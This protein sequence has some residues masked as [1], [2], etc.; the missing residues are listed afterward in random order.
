MPKLLAS[1]ESS[2]G[3]PHRK[4]IIKISIDLYDGTLQKIKAT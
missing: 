2:I 3:N 1:Y 4:N